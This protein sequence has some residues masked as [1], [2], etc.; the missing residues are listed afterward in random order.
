M[1]S[2]AQ[3][4]RRAVQAARGESPFDLLLIDAQI[5]DMATGEIRPA[6]VGIVGEMIASVHPRG[7]REDAHEV[8]SLAGRTQQST[9]EINNMLQRLLAGVSEAVQVMNT[10]QEHSKHTVH[11]TA[12]ISHSLD[13]VA[14][15]V[16]TINDMNLQI[17]TAAE[18]Q[19]AVSE[20][21][22]RNLVAI[23]HIVE[24]LSLAA[25]ESELTTRD[26]ADTGHHLKEL[27]MRFR[28]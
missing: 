6:D 26:L 28:Y 19:N 13:G 3:V 22:N 1:S 10:S 23:Q 5:I 20:E 15:A 12:Q 11:E 2:N 17:A 21:I 24:Q 27:V 9:L 4:R 8:R 7:S 16:D 18:E 25:E 14:A